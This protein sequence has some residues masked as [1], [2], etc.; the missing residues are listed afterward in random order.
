M[1][2]VILAGGLGTRLQPYTLFLPKPMLP[3]GNK[4][5]LEHIIG[6]VKSCRGV[7]HIVLCTSYL[8]RIIENYFEDG[9]RFGIKIEY[10]KSDKPMGTAG[11]LKTAEKIILDDTFVCLNSDHTYE[12]SLYDMIKEHRKSEAFV[13]IALLPYKTTLEYGF[14]DIGDG[15][16]GIYIDNNKRI[17]KWKEQPE[18]S[19]LINIGCYIIQP[20]FLRL[21]PKS[22][23]FGMDDAVKSSLQ[24]KKIVK[25]FKI[26][27]D[28]IDIGDKKSFLDAYKRYLRE[29]DT[30]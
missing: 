4:P 7:D 6:W 19:G 29:L 26:D 10:V 12:F 9:R 15:D 25:G 5:I 13:S 28:F 14:I 30:V 8:H 21:I 24:Q 17:I 3:L 20:E 18:I 27:S 1:K 22:R 11:Q 16:D 2:A 23:P